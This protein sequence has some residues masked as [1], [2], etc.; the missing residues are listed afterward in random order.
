PAPTA[1]TPAPA[2]ATEAAAT[3]AAAPE[4]AAMEAT[5][6]EAA[7]MEGAAAPTAAAAALGVSRREAERHRREEGGA[8][9]QIASNASGAGLFCHRHQAHL[10]ALL[11]T[12]PIPPI[13][14]RASRSL[15]GAVMTLI[16]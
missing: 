9:R 8:D 11:R 13:S 16:E 3:E 1:A 10:S 2:A 6:M 12:A 15:C 14:V 4:A 5:A 7:A